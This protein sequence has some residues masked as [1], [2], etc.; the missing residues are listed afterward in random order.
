MARGQRSL[1]RSGRS[2]PSLSSGGVPVPVPSPWAPWESRP[3]GLQGPNADPLTG[4]PQRGSWKAGGE[5]GGSL[6]SWL[7]L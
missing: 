1:R 5:E 4:L 3:A 7:G 6:S 2:A